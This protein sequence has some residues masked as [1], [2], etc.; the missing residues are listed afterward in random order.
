MLIMIL[1]LIPDRRCRR[2]RQ[3]FFARGLLALAF[4]LLAGGE[5]LA[6]LAV[7]EGILLLLENIVL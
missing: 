5:L 6:E 4:T 3:P 1:Q 7:F 2:L